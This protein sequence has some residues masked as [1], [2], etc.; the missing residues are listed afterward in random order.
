MSGS[1]AFTREGVNVRIE[2]ATE[3]VATM[4][5]PASRVLAHSLC[6]GL[7]PSLKDLRMLELGAGTGLTS[8]VAAQ[9]GAS[10]LAT[11]LPEGLDVLSRNLA[12]NTQGRAACES[13]TWGTLVP[14]H[15]QH[16]FDLI[17]GADITYV[18]ETLRPLVASVLQVA[19]TRATIIIAQTRTQKEYV[20][21]AAIL[22]NQ[23]FD[24]QQTT[25][26][27]DTGFEVTLLT[28]R[29]KEDSDKSI[30]QFLHAWFAQGGGDRVYASHQEMLADVWGSEPVRLGPEEQGPLPPGLSR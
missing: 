13:L 1:V 7:V 6:D 2:V 4:E 21:K 5:W 17:I 26:Y 25:A 24:L 28:G 20:D 16:S 3:C 22:L 8:A 30:E 14:E 15:L 18:E 19:S 23:F 12:A 27:T 9:L 11:E 29:R 10:V